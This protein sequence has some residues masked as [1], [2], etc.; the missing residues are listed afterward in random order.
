MKVYYK[1]I[2]LK[3]YKTTMQSP[4]KKTFEI[5]LIEPLQALE[6]YKNPS[7]WHYTPQFGV[8]GGIYSVF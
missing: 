8:S 7:Y 3:R 5:S 2:K 6:D 4:I 1:I